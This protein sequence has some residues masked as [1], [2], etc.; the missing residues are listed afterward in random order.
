MPRSAPGDAPPAAERRD[1]QIDAVCG[2]RVASDDIDAGLPDPLVELE[3]RLDGG[4][5]GRA[6]ADD[7]PFGNSSAR[8]KVGEVDS[9]G[10]EAEVTP[11][12]PVEE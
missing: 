9:R 1:R 2:S 4:L 6:E 8:S 3:H 11:R 12:E 5:P 7:E 10:A